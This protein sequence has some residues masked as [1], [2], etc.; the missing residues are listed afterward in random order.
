MR[1]WGWSLPSTSRTGRFGALPPGLQALSAALPWVTAILL[2]VM[3]AKIG[4]KITYEKGVLFDL[5]STTI[6]DVSETDAVALMLYTP[7]GILVFFD[8]TRYVFD[9]STQMKKFAQQLQLRISYT[10]ENVLLVLADRRISGGD[11]MKM[12]NIAKDNGARKI[13]FAEK[14]NEEAV[15]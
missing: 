13:L 9:D 10:P 14:R 4:G 2:F 8:D 15:K 3:I 5:P 12:A 7:E 11:F 6:G 1:R